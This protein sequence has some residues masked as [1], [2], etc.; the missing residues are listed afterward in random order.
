ME[1]NHPREPPL[2]KYLVVSAHAESRMIERDVLTAD[3]LAVRRAD[4]LLEW[5]TEDG[6]ENQQAAG[7][8]ERRIR[9]IGVDLQRR[10]LRVILESPDADGFSVVVTVFDAS[11]TDRRRYRRHRQ[12]RNRR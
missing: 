9:M 4:P 8:G 1:P 2:P 3:V 7:R 12:R 11:E 6:G 5:Q 10:L